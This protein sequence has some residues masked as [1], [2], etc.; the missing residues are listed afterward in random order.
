M[1]L[2]KMSGMV[3][4]AEELVSQK[5]IFVEGF[6]LAK[7]FDNNAAELLKEADILVASQVIML[8]LVC[9]SCYLYLPTWRAFD[10]TFVVPN[11]K[12]M[13]MYICNSFVVCCHPD[14]L[15]KLRNSF[16]C[17][18]PRICSCNFAI[19][20]VSKVLCLQE[21]LDQLENDCTDIEEDLLQRQ[22]Q[23]ETSPG[24]R[25]SASSLELPATILEK[26]RLQENRLKLQTTSDALQPII[27]VFYLQLQLLQSMQDGR[28]IVSKAME[29][30]GGQEELEEVLADLEVES[31]SLHVHDMYC[32][33]CLCLIHFM[34]YLVIMTC[35]I[36]SYFN[37]IG[38]WGLIS[39]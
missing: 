36:D 39:G 30:V 11:V 4:Q 29:L 18:L 26:Q 8:I 31:Y 20:L 17:V 24:M 22:V 38:D 21:E 37:L 1:K 13:Y 16:L 19:L 35:F 32:E 14:S 33:K 10:Y 7:L 3:R 6:P 34:K 5:V 27:N 9:L 12:Y 15:F 23:Q 25:K 28:S 2:Q